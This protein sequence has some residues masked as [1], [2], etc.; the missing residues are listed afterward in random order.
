MSDWFDP[1]YY[2]HSPEKSPQ[3]PAIGTLKS[4]RSTYQVGAAKSLQIG[5]SVTTIYRS[6]KEANPQFDKD[7]NLYQIV[8][9]NFSTAVRCASNSPKPFTPNK[10]S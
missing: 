10:R 8:N 5:G 9:P 6:G 2:K 3:G 1:Q 4:V 7:D